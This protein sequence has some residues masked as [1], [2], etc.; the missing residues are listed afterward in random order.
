MKLIGKQKET[1]EDF[2]HGITTLVA[3]ACGLIVANLYWS[4][5]II[6][7]ISQ[8]LHIAEKTAGVMVTMTQLGYAIGLFFLVPLGDLIENRLL[9]NCATAVCAIALFVAGLANSALT[10]FIAS[11]FIGLGA[12]AVQMLVPYASHLSTNET[13]GRVVGKV[14]GGL[15][16]GVM[17]ARPL[18]SIVTQYAGWHTIFFASSIAMFLLIFA[19]QKKLPQRRVRSEMNYFE[20]ILSMFKLACTERLLQRRALYQFFLFS[21]FSLYWTAI[22]LVLGQRF[23]MSQAGI[24]LFGFVAV[25]GA[26]AAPIAGRMGDM[27]LSKIAARVSYALILC[28]FIL[29]HFVLGAST[30]SLLLLVLVAVVIDFGLSGSQITNQRALYSLRPEFLSR[31]NGIYMATF[32]IGGAIGS[33]LGTW[34]Y[35]KGGWKLTTI[36]GACLPLCTILFYCTEFIGKKKAA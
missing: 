23:H 19:L 1:T 26:T 29:A 9:I 28:A 7:P 2:P 25:A 10:F 30:L 36:A 15:M 4:Q 18:T 3:V 24:A 11:L 22:P 32:F 34:T 16:I 31:I 12:S 14:M 33:S 20:L 17:I 5:P 6:E 27:G 13:R 8:H 35:A 21:S